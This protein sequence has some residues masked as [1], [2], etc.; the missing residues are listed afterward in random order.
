MSVNLCHDTTGKPHIH[1]S[2]PETAFSSILQYVSLLYLNG[3]NHPSAETFRP[4]ATLLAAG[5]CTLRTAG[6]TGDGNGQAHTDH[7]EGH[8]LVPDKGQRV[9]GETWVMLVIMVPSISET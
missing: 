9:R 5:N 8:D 2:N 4:F 7:N 1:T 6:Q 3:L